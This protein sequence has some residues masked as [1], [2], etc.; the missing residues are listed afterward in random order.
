[1]DVGE[2]DADIVAGF[3]DSDGFVCIGAPIASKPS[4]VTMSK[5]T[6]WIKGSSSTT[7]T[8]G[9]RDETDAKEK[10]LLLWSPGA[11]SIVFKAKN[12]SSG[13]SFLLGMYL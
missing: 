10:A 9:R 12:G 5:A 1:M 7:S 6:K 13:R 4:W 11:V 3:E 8:T 2:Y